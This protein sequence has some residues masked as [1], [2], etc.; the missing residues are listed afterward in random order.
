VGP[1]ARD[2]LGAGLLAIVMVVLIVLLVTS[3]MGADEG[4]EATFRVFA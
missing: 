4:A 2:W 3:A 1:T